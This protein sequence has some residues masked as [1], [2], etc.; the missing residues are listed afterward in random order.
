MLCLLFPVFLCT[1][2]QSACTPSKV[3]KTQVLSSGMNS[4]IRMWDHQTQTQLL[5]N[6]W[7]SVLIVSPW[8]ADRLLQKPVC[9]LKV[10]NV[11][12]PGKTTSFPSSQEEATRKTRAKVSAF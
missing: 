6:S 10:W 11:Q 7:R 3:Q 8:H 1:S 9:R 4:E 12:L 2:E 5:F